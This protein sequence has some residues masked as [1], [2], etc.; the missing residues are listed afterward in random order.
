MAAQQSNEPEIQGMWG[1]GGG[2]DMNMHDA[3]W[4]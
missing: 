1:C 4:L 3:H 2:T